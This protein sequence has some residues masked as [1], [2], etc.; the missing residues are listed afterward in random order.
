M[1]GEETVD[2]GLIRQIEDRLSAG[3]R[4]ERLEHARPDALV[5]A[6]DIAEQL[7]EVPRRIGARLMGCHAPRLLRLETR[8]RAGDMLLDRQVDMDD[9]IRSPE[10]VVEREQR[11]DAVDDPAGPGEQPGV[12]REEFLVLGRAPDGGVDRDMP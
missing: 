9:R 2:L 6:P 1:R 7:L 5:M 3:L 11:P 4:L 8:D 12:E 10:E